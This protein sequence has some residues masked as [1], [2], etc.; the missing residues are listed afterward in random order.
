MGYSTQTAH[1]LLRRYP[2]SPFLEVH[3]HA[4]LGRCHAASGDVGAAEADFLAAIEAARRT[5]LHFCEAMAAR[6]WIVSV[7][8]AQGRRVE[9]LV[10]LGGAL[11]RLVLPPGRYSALLGSGIDAEEAVAAAAAHVQS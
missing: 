7:L 5:A 10:V 6:D 1:C 4:T 8:D 3:L 9:G 2:F 11:K